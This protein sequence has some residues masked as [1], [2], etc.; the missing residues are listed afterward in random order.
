VGG[1]N[2][3]GTISINGNFTQTSTG[4]LNME[5]GPTASQYDQLAVT[6]LDTLGGTLSVTLIGGFIPH[7]GQLFSL[8]TYGSRS[9]T[10]GTLSLPTYSGG[11]FNPMYDNPTGTFSLWAV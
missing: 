2:S 5:I 11:H 7:S 8:L 6:G 9:G 4:V 3:A 10:F 1:I